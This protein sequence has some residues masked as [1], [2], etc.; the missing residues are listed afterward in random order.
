MPPIEVLVGTLGLI[1]LACGGRLL[2][3]S[4]LSPGPFFAV[5]WGFI[6]VLSLSSPLFD[7]PLYPVWHGAIWWISLQC[8]LLMIGDLVGQGLAR[9]STPRDPKDSVLLPGPGL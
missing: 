2:A 5:I 7:A 6:V 8:L 3:G 1:C 9:R 4:W